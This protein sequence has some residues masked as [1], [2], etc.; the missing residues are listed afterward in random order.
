METEASDFSFHNPG[1]MRIG[2]EGK[3]EAVGGSAGGQVLIPPPLIEN[4]AR[5]TQSHN[6][7][8]RGSQL[9]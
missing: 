5:L 3:C 6:S 9:P 4:A 2:E 7:Q 8:V 1:V